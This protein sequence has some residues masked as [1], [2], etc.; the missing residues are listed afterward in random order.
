MGG[1]WSFGLG[2]ASITD[3]PLEALLD[4]LPF[5]VQVHALDDGFTVRYRNRRD[6]ERL[7]KVDPEVASAHDPRLR[8]LAERAAATRQRGHVEISVTGRGG[9]RL[10]W[11]WTI[12]PLL[13]AGGDVVG[14]ISVVEDITSPVVAR[15]RMEDALGQ[16]MQLLLEIAQLA[17]EQDDPDELLST[18]A[19]RVAGLLGAD[20]VGFYEYCPD[21]KLL[22]PGIG[23]RPDEF[24]GPDVP[25]TLPCDPGKSDLAAQVVF[26][27]R[28][29]RGTV[30][31]GR[32]ELWE[33]APLRDLTREGDAR[34]IL[35]PWRAGQERMGV[36]L[37]QRTR[38]R[39]DFTHE[40]GIAL[41]AAGHAAGLVC[42]RKRAERK[43]VE[44]AAELESL[45]QAKSHFLRLASHE[46]RGP[47]AL[48][49][50]YVSMVFDGDV[51]PERRQDVHRIVLQALDRMNLLL[52]QLVDVTRLQENRLQ[53]E[54]VE[55]DLRD[56]VR[57]SA[58]RV[59][60]LLER[61]REA[62]FELDLP[63]V[64]VPVLVDVLRIEM[65]LQNLLDNAFKYSVAGDRVQCC[66]LV[67][68]GM[69]AVAVRDEGI[70]ISDDERATLFTR[71]GRAVNARNSHIRGTGLG[72]FISREIA[73]MHGGDISVTSAEGHGS[74][75]ELVLP[76]PVAG[77]EH[78]MG[79]G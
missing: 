68:G 33:Y 61:G 65:A 58:G 69:V 53:L 12:S 49:N 14:L 37:A 23:V 4:Q 73:R 13:D 60:P 42:Q 35:V 71:F 52:G 9:E 1:D 17:E 78:V 36:V 48:L 29:Y 28:I 21:R 3:A 64:P 57:S 5:C 67:E 76:A 31:L 8:S 43:L 30:D 2:D 56:L 50:G 19:E 75:F 15:R 26:N 40:E 62:D 79:D 32:Q 41:M 25:A 46:L 16:G 38:R 72:L 24:G 70:G 34:V 7:R 11:D 18:V 51:P 39:D 77:L 22:A 27:G 45:E 6:R 59:L 47:V 20:R 54:K 63:E 66:L 55:V 74:C 10:A 44:R